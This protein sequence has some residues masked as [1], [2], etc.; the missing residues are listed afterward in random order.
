[1]HATSA[2]SASSKFYCI[3]SNWVLVFFWSDVKIC[4]QFKHTKNST[5]DVSPLRCC[6]WKN[7][8]SWP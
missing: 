5:I 6:D 7:T 4:E 2:Q 1:M 3:Y 8:F